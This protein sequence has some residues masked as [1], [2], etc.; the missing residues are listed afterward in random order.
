MSWIKQT[1][2]TWLQSVAVRV[3][4]AGKVPTHLAVIMDGNR[5]FARKQNMR[6]VEGH[7]QGFDKL[8]EVLYW[9]SELGVTEV[10][11]YAFSIENFKRSKDEVDGLLDL[12]LQK[13]R[14]MLNEMDKIHEHGVCIRVL[15]NLSYLPVELQQVVAEVVH[16]TQGN[17]RCFLNICLS[18]T[19]R[20]EICKAMQELATGVEKGILSPND[21]SEAALS[22]AM[23]SRKSRDPELLIRTSGEVRLSDFML[24]QSSR[25]VIEFTT[26]LWPE[27]TI[28]HLLAAILCYQRQCGLVE[29]FKSARPR[30]R[31]SAD[32]LSL[33]RFIDDVETRWQERLQLMRLGQTAQEV[34]VT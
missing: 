6:S 18:Y 9:C 28:W 29:A 13:L 11:V 3:L 19:S 15:G 12:A 23:Y 10:T 24:W 17:S 33:Q 1:K 34:V 31:H 25:S 16:E 8:A 4:K 5:R 20:D 32:D 21:V 22:Q 2:L 7:V 14:N 26:V 27:F 30:E